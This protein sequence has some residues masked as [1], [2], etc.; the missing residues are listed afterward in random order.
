MCFYVGD[1][2]TL[3]AAQDGEES[4]PP[5]DYYVRNDSSVTRVIPIAPTIT[6]TAL[7]NANN[8]ISVSYADWLSQRVGDFRHSVWIDT[9]SGEIVEIE[10]QYL[11]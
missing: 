6:V 10:E 7:N 2:A 5:N 9:A 4:P 3:A 11:P 1:N 8:P